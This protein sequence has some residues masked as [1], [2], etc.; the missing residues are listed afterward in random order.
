MIPVGNREPEPST[1]LGTREHAM[2]VTQGR[3]PAVRDAL[4]WLTF[5]HLPE[6]LQKYVRPFYQTAVEMILNVKDSPELTYSLKTMTDAKD[7]AV[8]AGIRSDTG[9]AG[10]V[11]RPQTVVAP[12]LFE[13]D[14][15]LTSPSH[16]GPPIHKYDGEES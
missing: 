9:Q 12:P 13:T 4:Q 15:T 7:W 3:N 16:D 8:R 5:A 14:E 10:S 1:V 6:P 2:A 11:P